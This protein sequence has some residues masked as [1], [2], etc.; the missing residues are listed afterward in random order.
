MLRALLILQNLALA[1]YAVIAH[2]LL[3]PAKPLV[4]RRS[5]KP[6]KIIFIIIT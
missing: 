2:T 3:V 1:G 6:A 5:D 4:R